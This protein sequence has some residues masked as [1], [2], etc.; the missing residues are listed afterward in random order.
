MARRTYIKVT[1]AFDEDGRVTPLSLVFRGRRIQIDRLIERRQAAATKAGGQ[2]MRYTVR[3]A[4]HETYLFQD[5]AQ[6]W[7]V[8]EKDDV[9]EVPCIDGGRKR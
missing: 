5:D 7:F 1:A 2:G 3:I 9:R 4:S 8:E 6:R